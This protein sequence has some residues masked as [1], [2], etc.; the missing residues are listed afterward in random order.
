[1][2]ERGTGSHASRTFLDLQISSLDAGANATNP[3][4]AAMP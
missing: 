4:P 2:L 1:M 3:E